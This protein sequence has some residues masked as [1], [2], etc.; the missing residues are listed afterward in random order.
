VLG[1]YDVSSFQTLAQTQQALTSAHFLM[2][3]ATQGEWYVNPEHA[4]QVADARAA[5]VLVGHYHFADHVGRAVAEADYF[6]AHADAQPGDWVGLDIESMDGTWPERGAYALAFLA[7]IAKATGARPFW[8]TDLYWRGQLLLVAPNLGR[9][10]LLWIATTNRPAGD[11]GIS[12]WGMHQWSTA[13]GIDHDILAAQG[14]AWDDYAIPGA[15]MSLASDPTA[16]KIIEDAFLT[17]PV[18]RTALNVGQILE[19]VYKATATPIDPATIT[20]ALE[21]AMAAHPP[22]A[23]IDPAPIAAA[24]VAELTAHPLEPKA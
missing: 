7:R 16:P 8:Y 4:A 21:A 5:H 10:Y 22:T 3:K 6:L 20:A 11:P 12:G 1:G 9:A 15:D 14:V 2:V 13:G 18:G 24:V 23:L 17:A 19:L